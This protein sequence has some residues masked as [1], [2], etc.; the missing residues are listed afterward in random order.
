MLRRVLGISIFRDLK[1]LNKKESKRLD[2][3]FKILNLIGV[4]TKK[5][6]NHGIKIHGKPELDFIKN[7]KLKII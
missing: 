2:W 1:E 5:I 6:S 3:G 4:K 7:M